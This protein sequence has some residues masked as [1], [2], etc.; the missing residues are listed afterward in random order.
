MTPSF[1]RAIWRGA[2]P[3][4]EFDARTLHV[5]VMRR[6]ALMGEFAAWLTTSGATPEIAFTAHRRL[7][8]SM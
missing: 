7:V 2:T 3:L 6:S 4:T 8:R 5:L 1:M